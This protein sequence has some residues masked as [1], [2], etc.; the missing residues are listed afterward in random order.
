MA[1]A[2]VS[3]QAYLIERK[4]TIVQ[5]AFI[6]DH[7]SFNFRQFAFFDNWVISLKQNWNP[8]MM[9][10]WMSDNKKFLPRDFEDRLADAGFKRGLP[11]RPRNWRSVLMSMSMG[12]RDCVCQKIG[13]KSSAIPQLERNVGTADDVVGIF[14]WHI[15]AAEATKNESFQS[16][17]ELP[18]WCSLILGRDFWVSSESIVEI[19]MVFVQLPFPKCSKRRQKT[20][21]HRNSQQYQ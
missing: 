3:F 14:I 17:Y 12:D 19:L 13:S 15:S 10:T 8:S 7:P 2:R 18:W 16:Y 20:L 9:W 21:L 5:N 1:A 6:K 4:H 11:V